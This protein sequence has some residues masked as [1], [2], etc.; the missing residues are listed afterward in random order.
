MRTPRY[1]FLSFFLIVLSLL[2]FGCDSEDDKENSAPVIQ[3][4]VISPNPVLPGETAGLTVTAVDPDADDPDIEFDSLRYDWSAQAGEFITST[5]QAYVEWRAPTETGRFGFEILVSDGDAVT[6]DSAFI[7]VDD[8]VSSPLFQA[9]LMTPRDSSFY[10]ANM[11]IDFVG[12]IAGWENLYGSYL[13]VEWRSD[14]DGILDNTGPDTLGF[15]GFTGTLSEDTHEIILDVR[16]NEAYR[17]L[18]TVTVNVFQED[19]IVLEPVHRNYLENSL[20]WE[21]NGDEELFVS[22]KVMRQEGTGGRLMEIAHIE[23]LN[24]TSFTDTSIVLG[25]TYNYILYVEYDFGFTAHS[26]PQI[27]TAGVYNFIPSAIRDMH[28]DNATEYLYVTAPALPDPPGAYAIDVTANNLDYFYWFNDSLPGEDYDI[29]FRP[30]GFG[31]A[32]DERKLFVGSIG[33]SAVWSIDLDGHYFSRIID[34]RGWGLEPMYLD[35]DDDNQVIYATANNRF[36]LRMERFGDIYNVTSISD[37]RL[38]YSNS[39]LIVDDETDELYI[40]EIGGFPASLFKYDISTNPPILIYEDLHNTLGYNLWDVDLHPSG[41]SL[42]I[43]CESPHHVQIIN[44]NDF[45]ITDMLDTGPGTGPT[46]VFIAPDGI[47]CY[48]G[49]ENLVQK[50]NLLTNTI[51]WTQT[52]RDPISRDG[53]R[54]SEDGEILMVTTGYAF[55]DAARVFIIYLD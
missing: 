27:I 33:D 7:Q 37:S 26:Y 49:S 25:E 54:A 8:E 20:T 32:E 4:I 55:E 36:P 6:R 29:L 18:D 2:I 41:N 40:S 51:E 13:E 35:Y 39:M 42:F 15:V 23:D 48:T 22:Y 43:A 50:W 5:D 21:H 45:S 52:F 9:I 34:L 10:T 31:V 30:W 17:S 46:A 38:I 14:V 24:T 1:L 53:I 3:S 19:L 12:R 11:D 16:V 28:Y 47:T 44:P